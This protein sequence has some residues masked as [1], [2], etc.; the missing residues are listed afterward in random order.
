M[1]HKKSLRKKLN[2]QFIIIAAIA[3][4]VTAVSSMLLFYVIL[5]EQVHDDLKSYAYIISNMDDTAALMEKENANIAEGIRITWVERDGTV[6]GDNYVNAEAMENQKDCPEIKEAMEYGESAVVHCSDVGSGHV[7]FYAICLEDGS[8]L[9]V[10][11]ESI[12]LCS[13]FKDT[14]CMT[15]IIAIVILGICLPLSRYLAQRLLSP[16]EKMAANKDGFSQDNIYIELKPFITTIKEQHINILNHAKMRQEFTANVS[17][18][19]KTPLTAILGY[20]ELIGSGM[21]DEKDT[22]HFTNEIYRSS[23]RLLRLINDIIK[24]SELDESDQEFEM[25]Q[26]NLYQMAQNCLEMMELQADKQDIRLTLKGEHCAI[27]ANK[28]LIEELLYNLCSNA[29]RYN[30]KGGSVEITVCRQGPKILLSVKDTGIGIPKEHQKRVF[31]RFYRVDKSRS[32]QSGGTGLGLAIVK[33]IVAQH[34]AEI[35]LE[36]E[37]GKGTEIRILFL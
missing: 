5:K 8:V 9:R 12:S 37:K 29:I 23:D 34:N 4:L 32:K 26:V 19:L 35:T 15:I 10:G 7:L 27:T 20:A 1:S 22:R 17:H 30:N 11:K 16:I 31:E 2:M 24:L 25:E 28:S 36:S 14:I 6:S 33:H 3:I 21:A 18:E 13:I